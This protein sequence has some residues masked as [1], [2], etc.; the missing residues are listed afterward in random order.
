[1]FSDSELK[2]FMAA[3]L[4]GDETGGSEHEVDERVQYAVDW[5]GRIRVQA[6]L[7]DLILSGSVVI[8]VTPGGEIRFIKP[9]LESS[10]SSSGSR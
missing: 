2:S 4:R 10:P 1:M 5:G 9:P 6:L 8:S 3:V 7:L